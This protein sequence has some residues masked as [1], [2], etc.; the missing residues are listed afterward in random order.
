[1]LSWL[2][3]TGSLDREQTSGLGLL[4]STKPARVIMVLTFWI[5]FV[6]KT[7]AFKGQLPL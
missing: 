5:C 3:E 2:L 7:T 6:G 4:D 1:M